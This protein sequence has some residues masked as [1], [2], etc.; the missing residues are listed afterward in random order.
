MVLSICSGLLIT[1]CDGTSQYW[2][3]NKLAFFAEK[4]INHLNAE[5]EQ[6]Q[7]SSTKNNNWESQHYLGT[8]K[9]MF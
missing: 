3:N 8:K 7:D 2:A 9:I 5:T 4:A 1:K 6:S